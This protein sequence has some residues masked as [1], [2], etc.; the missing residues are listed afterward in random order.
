M[1]KN[2]FQQLA[3][4]RLKEARILLSNGFYEGSYYLA[5]YAVECAI[6]AC[7]AKN[8]KRFDFPDKEL[9]NKS[10]SHD[11]EQLIKLAG[12]QNQLDGLM[13]SN[14][15]FEVNWTIV[16]DWSEQKRYSTQ[17]P[18]IV[19]KEFYS[20]LTARQNG[21]MVWLRSKW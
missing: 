15:K 18:D 17:I 5:G 13:K 20:A 21:I 14:K 2:D 4:I 6:K 11:L 9:A 12:L 8:V 3:R 16:K 10:Y 19:A 1:T 7:I